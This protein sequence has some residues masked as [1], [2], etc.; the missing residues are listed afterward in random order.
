MADLNSKIFSELRARGYDGDLGDMLAAFKTDND[1]DSWQEF[2][3][4]L[5]TNTASADPGAVDELLGEWA[6]GEDP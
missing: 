2:I 1:L 3:D 6:D 4:Y 5:D